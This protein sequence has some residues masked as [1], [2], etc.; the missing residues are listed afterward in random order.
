MGQS[1]PQPKP[2]LVKPAP[3]RGAAPSP[4]KPAPPPP[5]PVNDLADLDPFE[6]KMKRDPL[7]TSSEVRVVV[8]IA[9]ETETDREDG[10]AVAQSLTT[11]LSERRRSSEVRIEPIAPD[12]VAAALTRQPWTA[13]HLD[14]LLQVLDL[15]DHVVG[16]R[17][18][19]WFVELKRMLAR[20]PWRFLMA[21]P[22][23]DLNSPASIHRRDPW[24]GLILQSRGRFAQVEWLAK[25]TFQTQIVSTVPIPPLDSIDLDAAGPHGVADRWAVLTQP[26]FQP[27]P[28]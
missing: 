6:A 13:A 18:A 21:V 14:P 10:E 4:P 8:L 12:G 7:P 5:K 15:A 26:R 20:W 25:A 19:G 16:H 22:A 28:A 17:R 24:K 11:L 1:K 3:V 2:R 23:F 27:N 9:R